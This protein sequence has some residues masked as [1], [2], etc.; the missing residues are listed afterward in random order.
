MPEKRD[1]KNVLEVFDFSDKV[2][3]EL[4]EHKKDDGKISLFE[5]MQTIASSAPSAYR[6]GKDAGEIKAELADLDSAEI[7]EIAR[8]GI[9]VSQKV[10]TL[11]AGG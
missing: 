6:A 10:M 2:L 11:L 7:E 9:A 1:I 4:I 8:R 3:D 5:W